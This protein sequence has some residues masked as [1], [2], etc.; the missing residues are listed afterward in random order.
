M[1]A[2][3]LRPGN[4]VTINNPTSWLALKGIPL[5]VTGVQLTTDEHFPNSKGSVSLYG[6]DKWFQN[7]FNQFE[8][9]IEPILLT[10]E[11]LL[12]FGWVWNSECKSYERFPNYDIRMNLRFHDVSMSYTMFN[13]VL[14][15]T[16]VR[17]ILYVHQLQNLFFSLTGEDLKFLN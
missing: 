10:E 1:R 3:E 16:V 14:K 15:A 4:F 5:M 12:K 17:R 2:L 9:F 13:H 11:W 6:R 7:T 8:E